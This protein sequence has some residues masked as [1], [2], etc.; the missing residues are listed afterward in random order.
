MLLEWA[1]F[2]RTVDPDIITGYNI[3]NFDFYFLLNRAKALRVDRQFCLLGRMAGEQSRIKDTVFSSKAYGRR[4]TRSA[5]ITGRVQMDMLQ[6]IQRDYKL[7]SYSLN[8]VSAHFLGQQKEDV[9]Y[10]IITDLFNGTP[11]DRRRLAVYC[12]KDAMLPQRLMDKL[13][14][15]FNYIEMS[16]VTGVPMDYLLTRG[17]QIKV[18][19]QLYR[20]AR[21]EGLA[22]PALKSQ[23]GPQ[24]GGDVNYEGAT[25]IEPL[26]GY[27]SQPIATL[28]FASLYP[29]I[30]MAHNLCYSTLLD[31]QT[32]KSLPKDEFTITP[33]GNAFVKSKVR[34]GILPRILE[35]LL[36]ARKLAKQEL[37]KESDPFR[38][39]VLDGRQLALKVSANSVY[40]FTG[41][42]VGKLP[43]IAISSSVT[44]FGREMIEQTKNAVEARY[45][46][47]NNYSHDAIVIYG[48]TDSVMVKFGPAEVEECMRL[49]KEAADFVSSQ[50][51]HPIKL[52]FE[53]VYFPYLLMNKKR[54]AGLY[55][56]RTETW[57]KMD[58][59]GIV[60]VR[61]DNCNLVKNV[62]STCL[63]KILKEQDIEGAK[64]YAKKII[65]DLLNN[66]MDLSHLVITKALVKTEYAVKQAHVELVE[67]MK[68]RDAGVHSCGTFPLCSPFSSSS[69]ARMLFVNN[70]RLYGQMYHL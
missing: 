65:S 18:V 19:S 4:E 7:R 2:F 64:E 51:L 52:E 49:G 31:E 28:D 24:D 11:D 23:G 25:V 26:R 39:A 38:R 9:H 56:T 46:V 6:V 21:S 36:A 41:A 69:L 27:Y 42:T 70:Y 54:Y 22:I 33:T 45:K 59:K 3:T 61:R 17:Q 16:R 62:I 15:L 13:M 8:S 32:M 63:D 60:T 5:T 29:S 58:A 37:K 35:E 10:S 66:R 57:D 50:F 20:K 55:W 68:K 48:D 34:K 40:G 1:K 44:A 53:K 47:E 67:R 12:L 43:C 30:M 14:V